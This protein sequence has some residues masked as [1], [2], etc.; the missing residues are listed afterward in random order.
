MSAIAS[1]PIQ[2][3]TRLAALEVKTGG[4][5]LLE[6]LEGPW[7]QLA[8][9]ANAV[10]FLM[11]EWIRA[12]VQAFSPGDELIV[13]A[14]LQAGEPVAI[15]P[16][17]RKWVWFHGLHLCQLTGAANAHSVMFDVLCVPG[18]SGEHAV[19][20]IWPAIRPLKNW[21]VLQLP[22]IPTDG[23]AQQILE[24]AANEGFATYT[25]VDA[26]SPILHP[27][28]GA[29]GRLDPQ[30]ATSSR[31]RHELRR[32]TRRLESLLCAKPELVRRVHANRAALERFYALEAS[33]WK[34]SRGT[35]IQ[36][37]PETALYYRQITGIADAL[38]C[39]NL[40]SLEKDGRM[41]AA[42]LGLEVADRYYGLKMA[43]DD[44]FR[45]CGPG[46]L[47][48]AAVTE[49]CINRGV[50]TF[51]LGGKLDAYKRQWTLET[52][53]ILTGYVFNSAVRSQLVFHAKKWLFPALRRAQ[54]RLFSHSNAHYQGTNQES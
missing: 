6:H 8:L 14:V 53:R 47:I 25:D 23:A 46:H 41:I 43:Y 3:V 52:T 51:H 15:L 29:D 49:D 18:A 22:S 45:S 24:Q 16:L 32:G 5:E 42:C 7:R 37:S 20:K 40:H 10:P 13:I 36:C 34:G 54:S 4:L 27:Q 12:H 30:F 44:E 50:V 39:L 9:K 38:G 33:G 2:G 48:L 28:P 17:V 19:R 26:D 21:H 1:V 11:P 35:A 31:F